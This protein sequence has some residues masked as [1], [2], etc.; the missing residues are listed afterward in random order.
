MNCFDCMTT[1]SRSV[2]SAYGAVGAVAVCS[3]C[4]V[5]LC[6][7]HVRVG[8]VRVETHSIGNPSVSELPGRRVFCDVCA[9]A[10]ATA[11]LATTAAAVGAA[12]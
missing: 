9:P 3:L 6:E 12:G 4:G 5:G 2:A 1:D 11:V 10:D 7:Q 8:H